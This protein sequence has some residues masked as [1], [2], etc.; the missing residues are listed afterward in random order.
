MSGARAQLH[1][2]WRRRAL[3]LSL[4][5]FVFLGGFFIGHQGRASSVAPGSDADPLVA[6]SYVDQFLVL[7]V[8]ELA[9]GQTLEGGAGTEIIL[10]SGTARAIASPL[11]GVCDLT[12]GRDLPQGEIVKANHLLL[13][14]RADGRGIRAETAV[15]VMVRGPHTIK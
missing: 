1:A 11:G 15:F 13:V 6:R 2:D 3:L 10:R 9:K 8:V 5:G 4:A 7:A 12:G 14:P